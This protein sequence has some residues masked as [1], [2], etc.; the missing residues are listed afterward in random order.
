MCRRPVKQRGGWRPESLAHGAVPGLGSGV[1]GLTMCTGRGLGEERRDTL[2]ARAVWRPTHST[3]G[4]CPMEFERTVLLRE[5]HDV[6]GLSEP[7]AGYLEEAARVCL[8]SRGHGGGARLQV[9]GDHDIVMP[10]SYDLPDPTSNANHANDNRP[11]EDGPCCIALLLCCLLKGHG[12]VPKAM[13]A[14]GV[15]YWVGEAE[16][17]RP[18]NRKARLEASGIR[19]GTRHDVRA[20]LDGKIR[21][22]AKSDGVYGVA[23]AVV[24]FSQPLAQLETRS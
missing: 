11:T 17:G 9:F 5:L 20:R 14:E 15:A 2:V 19:H 12:L 7:C 23:L 24:E 1:L 16:E 3:C 18:F 10:I 13:R 4:G 6:P 8:A 22:T 21:T